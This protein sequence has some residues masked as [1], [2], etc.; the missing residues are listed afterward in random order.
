VVEHEE[1]L[2]ETMLFLQRP[3]LRNELRIG[4]LVE[5]ET[6]MQSTF[7]HRA[8]TGCTIQFFLL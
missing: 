2:I 8:S 4:V 3:R 1:Q 7:V 6:E 5:V